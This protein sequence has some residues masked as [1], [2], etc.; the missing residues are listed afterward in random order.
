MF[1]EATNTIIITIINSISIKE[2]PVNNNWNREGQDED[3]REGAEAA[4]L[5]EEG[6]ILSI[7]FF[8]RI[9]ES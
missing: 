6:K 2:E 3:P 8:F 4:H 7:F 1:V 5:D 9:Y